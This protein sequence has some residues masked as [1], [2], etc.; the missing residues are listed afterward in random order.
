MVRRD[1]AVSPVV[2]VMLMLVVT[3]IIAA[4]VAMFSTGFVGD[5]NNLDGTAITTVKYIGV[6]GAGVQD[7]TGKMKEF[8]GDCG[9][10]FE[11]VSGEPI[12]LTNL[13][14]E[15]DDG[16]TGAGKVVV[17]YNDLPSQ[18][19]A[20]DQGKAQGV[21]PSAKFYGTTASRMV[22]YPVAAKIDLRDTV[23]YP[24]EKFLIV[25]EYVSKAGAVGIRVD[26]NDPNDAATAYRSGAYYMS[27]TSTAKI[28]LFD[29][30]TGTVLFEGR[31]ADGVFL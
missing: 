19:Y 11:V 1:D 25:A 23:I 16:G 26:R 5:L 10:V 27:A 28:K 30:S 6:D 22:P 8:S 17:S 9:L 20:P 2:G 12:D 4:S 24:G 3:V 21:T 15:F 7:F 13:A 29:E 31:L 14:I 18:A